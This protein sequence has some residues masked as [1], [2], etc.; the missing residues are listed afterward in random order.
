[1]R[2]K[3]RATVLILMH[4][5]LLLSLVYLIFFMVCI[6]KA[7]HSSDSQV[8]KDLYLSQ[9]IEQH[10]FSI[11]TVGR[12]LS[13]SSNPAKENLFILLDL[14]LPI[15]FILTGIPIQI[16]LFR[17]QRNKHPALQQKPFNQTVYRR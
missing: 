3:L 9:E 14:V 12:A 11:Y 10:G 7:N 1:M 5:G 8:D 13:D 15:L 6:S 4:I 17:K 16:L 2:T